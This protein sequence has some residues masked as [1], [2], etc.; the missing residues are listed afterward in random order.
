MCSCRNVRLVLVL[1]RQTSLVAQMS[2][3]VPQGS[4]CL[5]PSSVTALLTVSMAQMKVNVVSVPLTN[6]NLQQ[7]IDVLMM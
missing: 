3:S 5:R 7:L 1:L 4:V 2:A 6:W